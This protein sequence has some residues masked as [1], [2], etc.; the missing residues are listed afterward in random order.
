MEGMIAENSNG[1][2][3]LGA[4]LIG[5]SCN[6]GDITKLKIRTDYKLKVFGT[7]QTK[8]LQQLQHYV[9]VVLKPFLLQK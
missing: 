3:S 8:I 4:M 5:C 1:L 9:P 7:E 2:G 6:L